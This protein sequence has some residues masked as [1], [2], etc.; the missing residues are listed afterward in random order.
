MNSKTDIEL[1]SLGRRVIATLFD[2]S[3][4]IALGVITVTAVGLPIKPSDSIN[5]SDFGWLASQAVFLVIFI[6][7][8]S[9]LEWL[10]GQTIG[11]KIVGIRV[12]GQ[13][14]HE[15]PS[16]IS[17]IARNVLRY[18]DY[19]PYLFPIIGVVLILATKKRQRLGDL[20]AKTY[21]VRSPNVADDS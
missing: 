12:I 16:F 6:I 20:V 2:T 7:Y 17:A 18:V 5:F 10:T 9:T 11:K 15:N 14:D 1:A 8:F 3:I 21:V 4:L 13:V 19:I